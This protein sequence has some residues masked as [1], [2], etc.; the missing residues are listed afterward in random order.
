[1]IKDLDHLHNMNPAPFNSSYDPTASVDW[2][3]AVA[4]AEQFEQEYGF[5]WTR[6]KRKEQ[7]NTIYK[8]LRKQRN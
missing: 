6:E 4:I 1:M 2:S 5:K 7:R 8:T 3:K